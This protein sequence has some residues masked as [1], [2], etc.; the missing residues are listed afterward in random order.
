M[1]PMNI[2]FVC[3]ANISRS[4]LSERLF[5]N[6]AERNG[7][8]DLAVSSAGIHAVAGNPP[9][10]KMSEY[11]ENLG[12]SPDGHV[13]RQL[14]DSHIEWADVI[15]VMEKNHY[16]RIESRWPEAIHK[17][18]LLGK[19]VS[20]DGSEDDIVD[21]YGRSPYHY[22]LSQSQIQMAVDKVVE[23]LLGK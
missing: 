19:Y 2:L 10:P 6:E 9:D 1:V 12:V 23:R 20:G 21:P 15:L 17:V 7:A 14:D 3:T 11:L 4:Y 13:S 16:N 5:K 18:E 8:I 22:R